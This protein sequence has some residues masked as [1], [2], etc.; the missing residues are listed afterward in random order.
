MTATTLQD[1]RVNYPSLLDRFELRGT[2]YALMNLG[3][4]N[5]MNPSTGIVSPDLLDKAMMSWGR[6]IDIPVMT[7]APNANGTGLTCTFSGT[8]SISDFVNVTWV[9]VSNGFNM[10]PVKNFQ[11]EI[12]YNQEFA[13]KYTDAVR[14]M[15]LAVDGAVDT[16]LTAAITPAAE[17]GSSYIGVGNKYGAL[18]ADVIQVSLANRPDFFNDLVDIMAE[19]DILPSFD[20][21][22]S[23]NGRGIIS[24]LFAQGDAN[25]TNTQYQ[26]TQGD[27]DF[28]FSKR[29]TQTPATTD[30][31]GFV[32]PK[33]SYGI[34]HRVR[35]DCMA[36]NETTDG[37]IF[38]T[39]PNDPTLGATIGTLFSST[40][41]TAAVESGNAADTTSVLETHQMEVH[42]GILTPYTNF[43]TSSVPS[44]IRKYD[45]LN[46]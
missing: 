10:Q 33:G 6:G 15:A 28:H 38:G 23:T 36:G 20:S 25:S 12:S 21:P 4:Q 30:A 22:V 44:V 16:V 32:M 29:V 39:I 37:K 1:I 24:Q 9:T 19:D 14:N 46:T 7:P 41:G 2:N 40:C 8:E 13:R 27:Y 17:Y 35:P 26:F 34:I 3:I 11:N 42:Y 18:V 45:L 31:T 43:A 5:A